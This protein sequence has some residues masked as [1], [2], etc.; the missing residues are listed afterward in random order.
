[1]WDITPLVIALAAAKEPARAD[2]YAAPPT[3]AAG[4][5][6]PAKIAVA[7]ISTVIGTMVSKIS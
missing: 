7:A 1:M 4:A 2:T 3:P 6:T 5:V